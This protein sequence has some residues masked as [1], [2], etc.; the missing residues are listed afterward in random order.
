[1]YTLKEYQYAECNASMRKKVCSE[2]PVK[3]CKDQPSRKNNLAKQTFI[4]VLKQKV[5]NIEKSL[6]LKKL[7]LIVSGFL[8]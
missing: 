8:Y 4:P 2:S 7:I 5:D 6:V 1:M 3:M